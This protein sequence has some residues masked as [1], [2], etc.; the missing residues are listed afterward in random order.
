MI[1]F[2]KN[3]SFQCQNE[4]QEMHQFFFQIT[5]LVHITY[6][7][8]PN[9]VANPDGKKIIKEYQYYVLDDR[10]HGTLFVQHYFD[11]HWGYLQALG[12]YPIEHWFGMMVVVGSSNLHEVGTMQP[13]TP[14]KQQVYIFPKVI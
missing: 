7:H 10:D 5:I 3:Y 2:A 14:K 1:D 4:I 12:V 13:F 9:Y 11:L 8:N 6:H